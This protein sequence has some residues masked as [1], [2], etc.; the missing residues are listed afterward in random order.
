MK[1]EK[2][3]D[4][5][6][7]SGKISIYVRNRT[8]GP[9]D[10]YRVIQ[11]IDK[12]NK[13][14]VVHDALP[15]WLFKINLN[16][17]PSF[18]KKV[19][20]ALL[21]VIIYFR[22]MVQLLSDFIRRSQT[23]VIQREIFPKY[24][25]FFAHKV[26]IKFLLGKK[27]IWDFDDNIFEGE[28]SK[29]EWELLENVSTHIVVTSDYL[30]NQIQ[31]QYKEKVLVLATSD[32]LATIEEIAHLNKYREKEYKNK[33][34]LVWTGTA[35]NLRNIDLIFDPLEK[36]GCELKK[37]NKTL[38]LNIICNRP[39]KR[40]SENFILNNYK[41]SRKKAEYII[42]RSHIGIMP[43]VNVE[44]SKGKGGFK[45]IQYM[46]CGL[47]IIASAVGFNNTIISNEKYGFLC[48]SESDWEKALR[49]LC[50]NKDAWKNYSKYS[51]QNYLEKYNRKVNENVWQDIL[52]D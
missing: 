38:Q 40:K 12:M 26:A 37:E 51:L 9:S 15:D 41:W 16:M 42:C 34:I 23:I 11:Y 35:S 5:D 28:I 39:Y 2:M 24:I 52:K 21:F 48:D 17:S 22:R 8:Y 18:W 30:K 50:I 25:P 31:A 47:P 20:Q 29:S 1:Y 19:F 14:I 36:I 27:V 45:L 46:S 4:V 13:K 49:L 6:S 43:L 7:K 3:T 44:Y 32:K 33:V 10:Y